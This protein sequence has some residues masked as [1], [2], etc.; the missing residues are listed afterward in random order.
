MPQNQI[1][2]LSLQIS[3]PNS[4]QTSICTTNEV[5]DLDSSFDIWKN[6]NDA[7]THEGF[8]SHSDGFSSSIRNSTLQKTDTELSLS[9]SKTKTAT[10]SEAESVWKRKNFVRLRPFNGIPLY[11]DNNPSIIEKDSNSSLYPSCSASSSTFSRFNGITIESLRPQKFQ[12][13]NHHQHHLLQHH[14]QQQKVNQFGNSEFGNGFVRSRMMM[15]RQQSNKRNMRAPRMR[16]TSSL[17]NRFVHAVELLGGHERATPKSVLELMDVKDLTLAHVKSHLQMY[18]TVKNTDKPAASSDG[19]ENFMSLTQPHDQNKNYNASL[20]HDIG[21]T[22]NILWANSSSSNGTWTQGSSGNHFEELSTQE[23][24]STH[25]IGK[26]PQGSSCIQSRSSK[27]QNIDCPNP[28][29][30]FTLGR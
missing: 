29:L 26:L 9:N 12:Y 7:I 3:L 4:S 20:D 14:Q 28:N 27:D 19:D 24:L 30:E 13:M 8:K 1:P 25:H 21:Y 16:W 22:S 23:I 6:I 17:H 15:P 2:D 10:F 11:S 18:R 5:D